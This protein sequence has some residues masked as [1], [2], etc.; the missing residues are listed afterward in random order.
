[1]EVTVL[2]TGGTM[3]MPV[4]LCDCK[5]CAQTEI[6]R[7]PGLSIT[8][9]DTTIVLDSGPDIREQLLKIGTTSIDAFFFTH[10]HDD[11]IGGVPELHKLSAFR[12][13]EITAYAE[14]PVWEYLDRV[15]PWIDIDQRVLS[16]G[17]SISVGSLRVTPFRIAHS[18]R[19]PEL[20][21]EI[22][23]RTKTI[24]YAPDVYEFRSPHPKNVEILFVDGLYLLGKVF[25]DDTDHAGPDRLHREIESID[26]DRVV[27]LNTSEHWHQMT[28]A[29]F[30]KR[31][32]DYE[33]WSDFDSIQLSK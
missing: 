6:R 17:D 32:N 31:V 24:V 11:H 7:R 27:L 5:Y 4:A 3:G 33:I 21:F 19:F 10:A 15:F 23:D 20:G 18:E 25:P 16:V 12:E 28:T 8:K 13:M 22:T 1:M 29:E 2:G 9:E 14:N 26:A 30:E